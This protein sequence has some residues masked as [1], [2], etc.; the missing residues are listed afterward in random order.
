MSSDTWSK[1]HYE[2]LRLF[3]KKNTTLSLDGVAHYKHQPITKVLEQELAELQKLELIQWVPRSK[4]YTITEK[5]R[6]LAQAPYITISQIRVLWALR[7]L[8]VASCDVEISGVLTAK[9]AGCS[10]DIKTVLKGLRQQHFVAAMD[11]YR[12]KK[13]REVYVLGSKGSIVL[14]AYAPLEKLI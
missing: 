5:G 14:G 6:K 1:A 11:A 2:I 10:V 3:I 9:T 12:H 7:S 8:G 13:Y 4:S